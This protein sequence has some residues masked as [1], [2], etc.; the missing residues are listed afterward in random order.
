MS[1]NLT[2]VWYS[3]YYYHFSGEKLRLREIKA[4]QLE[5]VRARLINYFIYSYLSIYYDFKWDIM[6]NKYTNLSEYSNV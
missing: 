1:F 3:H 2:S 6:C 5:N 4:I